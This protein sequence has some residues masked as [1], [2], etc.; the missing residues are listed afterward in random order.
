MK[1]TLVVT[2][3]A[4]ALSLGAHADSP[5][6]RQWIL[7]SAKATGAGGEQFVTSVRIVNPN[8][9]AA[10][11]SLTYLAASTLDGSGSATGDNSTAAPVSVTV[12]AGQTL[13][14]EDI[15]SSRFGVVSG[16]GGIKVE[17]S[18]LTPVSVLSRT[19]VANARNAQGVPGT[20]ALSIPGQTADD[21]VGVGDTVY[22][23]YISASPSATAGFRSNL[24]LLN[25]VSANTVVTVKLAKG[26][27]STVATKD[28]TLGKQ[29][30]TQVNNL[31]AAFG[32]TAEDTNLTAVITVKSGGPVVV[33]AT[34]IDNAIS[35]LNYASPSKVALASNGAYGLVLEDGGYDLSGLAKVEA[36][37]PTFFSA[38]VALS[39]PAATAFVFQG[40][41]LDGRNTTFTKNPD[42]TYAMAGAETDGSASWS[43]TIRYVPDGTLQGSFTY[44]RGSGAS[45]PCTGK[46]TAISFV[47]ARGKSL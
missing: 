24:I 32:T 22:I 18:S 1:K 5:A 27:G 29:S 15:V 14:I 23:P 41:T 31:A 7:S 34:I 44:T 33:G 25:T 46:S 9:V 28:Y 26:D 37:V 12:P 13:A 47:G 20:Y 19:F 38:T 40:R 3:C 30:Q 16:A 21:A 45:V 36:G 4:L 2:L 35:S 8:A 11:V 17:T 6:A 42:G 43:G 39:C 10:T